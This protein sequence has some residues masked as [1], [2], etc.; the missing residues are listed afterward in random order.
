MRAKRVSLVVI[1][2]TVVWCLFA[3]GTAFASGGVYLTNLRITND[4]V[5]VLADD[6]PTGD[7]SGWLDQADASVVF[8]K[9]HTPLGLLYLNA[10]TSESATLT[11]ILDIHNPSLLEMS[12]NIFITPAN[13]QYR[14]HKQISCPIYFRFH[15]ANEKCPGGLGY[16][17][18]QCCAF[19]RPNQDSCCLQ[20]HTEFGYGEQEL[21]PS[22]DQTKSPVL[23]TGKWA[24]LLCAWTLGRLH[25]L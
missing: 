4:G 10:H 25:S 6:F 1:G 7:L 14:W 9:P 18:A 13:E 19:I 21:S 12:V 20:V 8:P 23:P 5:V 24:T 3:L 15:S 17:P 16:Q 11:R 22:D 2:A